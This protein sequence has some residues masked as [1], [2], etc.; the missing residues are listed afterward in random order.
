MQEHSPSA[1]AP[2]FAAMRCR[3][4]A[5]R[6]FVGVHGAGFPVHTGT[7]F[8]APKAPLTGGHE[9]GDAEA[10]REDAAAQHLQAAAIERQG[11]AHQHVQHHTQALHTT[12]TGWLGRSNQENTLPTHCHKH[13][14]QPVLVTNT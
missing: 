1:S 9:E 11:P 4:E 13:C 10:A 12:P 14:K 6:P 5:P 2:G 3:T 7:L 8:K